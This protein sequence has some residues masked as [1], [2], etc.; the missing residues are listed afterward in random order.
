M[1]KLLLVIATVV[2][3]GLVTK[4]IKDQKAEKDLWSEATDTG[5]GGGTSTN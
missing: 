5:T 1:K 2:T 3:A 4:K